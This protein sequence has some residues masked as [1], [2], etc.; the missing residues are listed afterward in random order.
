MP[1]IAPMPAVTAMASAPQ[2]VTR[3]IGVST[4]APPVLAP[5]K[6]RTARKISDPADTMGIR[7]LAG[8]STTSARGAA[9]PAEKVVAEVMPP[10]WASPR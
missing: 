4:A 7:R 8:E 6:P 9:A 10:G 2:N 1:T 5:R 3:I